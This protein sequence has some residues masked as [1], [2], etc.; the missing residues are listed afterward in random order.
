MDGFELA[1]IRFVTSRHRELQG[2]RQVVIVL[3]CLFSFWSRPYV[4]GLRYFGRFEAVVGLFL[5]VLPL[6]VTLAARPWLDGYYGRRFG[7]VAGSASPWSRDS[8]GWG[9]LLVAGASADI[10][11]YRQGPPIAFLIAGA[12]VALHV[13]VRDW[14]MR[15]HHLLTAGLCASGAWLFASR[16]GWQITSLDALVRGPFSVMILAHM[17]GACFDHRLLVRTLPFNPD[18]RDDALASDHADAL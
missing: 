8:I 15:R 7:S 13:V 4:E 10:A 11:T 12:L 9:L 3:A 17:V 14:P 1:R 2:L 6:L 18:V 5:S 16:A